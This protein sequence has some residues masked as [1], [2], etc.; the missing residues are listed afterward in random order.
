MID[1]YEKLPSIEGEIDFVNVGEPRHSDCDEIE[2]MLKAHI[3]KE[4]E[5]IY[6][7]IS[8]CGKYRLKRTLAP[9]VDW[10]KKR[11]KLV[12]DTEE[13]IELIK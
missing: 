5:S 12:Y 3:N 6:I 4:R 11:R 1:E 13:I 10:E 7:Y 9:R 8:V 2:F